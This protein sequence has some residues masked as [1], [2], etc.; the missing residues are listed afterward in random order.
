M[1][2]NRHGDLKV[3]L[4]LANKGVIQL[5][6]FKS[7]VSLNLKINLRTEHKTNRFN[8]D[9][10]SY[11]DKQWGENWITSSLTCLAVLHRTAH[12]IRSP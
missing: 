1:K 2:K 5:R 8:Y 9:I 7:L 10:I 6:K 3:V 4:L 11:I 12:T